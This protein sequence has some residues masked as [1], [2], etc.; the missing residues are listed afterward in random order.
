VEKAAS[1]KLQGTSKMLLDPL[2]MFKGFFFCSPEG[3]FGF[4]LKLAA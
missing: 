3:L 2:T 1:Y 4:F